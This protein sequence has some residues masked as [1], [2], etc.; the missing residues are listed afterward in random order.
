MVCLS[1]QEEIIGQAYKKADNSPNGH[2]N[3]ITH[4]GNSTCSNSFTIESKKGKK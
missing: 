3:F 2:A 1:Y 4:K